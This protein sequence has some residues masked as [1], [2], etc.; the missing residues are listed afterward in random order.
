[1]TDKN[2]S[3]NILP[4]NV[5]AQ[6]KAGKDPTCQNAGSQPVTL[7]QTKQ[8][9]QGILK[10]MGADQEC[11]DFTRHVFDENCLNIQ[12]NTEVCALACIGG[13]IENDL[14]VS[15]CGSQSSNTSKQKGCTRAVL[16]AIQQLTAITQMT[17]AINNTTE[18]SD[19]SG[20][21]TAKI[22]I[23]SKAPTQ[24]SLDAFYAYAATQTAGLTTA[25]AKARVNK[26]L[27]NLRPK[28]GISISNSELKNSIEGHYDL[29]NNTEFKDSMTVKKDIEDLVKLQVT[30]KIDTQLGLGSLSPDETSVLNQDI[31]KQINNTLI[32][33][34]EFA[35]SGQVSS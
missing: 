22:N 17:C 23:I 30:Q 33:F 21:Q 20:S 2:V 13:K 11:E 3:D 27:E 34:L 1:M 26:S 10:S 16:N 25:E 4:T 28:A 32:R 9:I 14:T 35:D 15:N 7:A 19:F 5:E 29:V 12:S 18:R 8:D 24:A 6:L 31:Q